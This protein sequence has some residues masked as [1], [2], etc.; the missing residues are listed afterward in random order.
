MLCNFKKPNS[1][2]GNT[3]EIAVVVENR[4]VSLPLLRAVQCSIDTDALVHLFHQ[5]PR[6][7]LLPLSVRR[8]GKWRRSR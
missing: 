7:A 5:D 2:G 8:N 6:S 1:M 3:L 4:F